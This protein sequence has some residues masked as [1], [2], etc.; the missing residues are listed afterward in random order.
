MQQPAAS[1]PVASDGLAALPTFANLEDAY[2]TVG[3]EGFHYALFQSDD[4]A[5]SWH[6]VT[7]GKGTTVYGLTTTA[8]PRVRGCG[9]L[10]RRVRVR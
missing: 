9:Q 4:A 2:R 10:H 1:T 5:Q 8:Q 6:P 3:S 7:F